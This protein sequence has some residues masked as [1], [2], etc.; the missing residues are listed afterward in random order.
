MS[1]LKFITGHESYNPAYTYKFHLKTT[2][3][4]SPFQALIKT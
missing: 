3:V 2:Q 4:F 1:A